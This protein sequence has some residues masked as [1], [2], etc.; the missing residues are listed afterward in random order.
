MSATSSDSVS[1]R[2]RFDAWMRSAGARLATA[3]WPV[4]LAGLITLATTTWWVTNSTIFD[5][6]VLRVQGN[7]HLTKRQVAKI[8][9][10]RADLNVLWTMPATIER[11][12]ERHPWIKEARVS[13]S[14]PNSLTVTIRERRPVA[15][16]PASGTVLAPDGKT[17]GQKKRTQSL[18]VI[19]TGGTEASS[20]SKVP[21]ISALAVARAMPPGVRGKVETISIGGGGLIELSLR[22]GTRVIYGD[23]AEIRFKALVLEALLDWRAKNAA[24]ERILD[25]SVPTAPTMI[26]GAQSHASS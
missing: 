17:L 2:F 4:A 13:R 1:S 21:T 14:L 9:E 7:A 19:A 12:L 8:G 20:P 23:A 15:V 3:R 18:P 6:R 24:R 10:L 16:L 5:L 22:D 26:P 11:R 25:V